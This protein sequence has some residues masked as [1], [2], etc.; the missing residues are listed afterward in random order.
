MSKF[1]FKIWR[2]KSTV[3]M[4]I[5]SQPEDTRN[6][7]ILFE[8]DGIKI[9]SYAYPELTPEMIYL[10][11]Y[12]HD[13]DN[14]V[15]RLSF[16]NIDKA[17]KYL[18]KASVALR[19]YAKSINI[20]DEEKAVDD[21]E[22]NLKYQFDLI[23]SVVV[24]TPIRIPKW[25][26]NKTSPIYSLKEFKI[27]R[28]STAAIYYD[29]LFLPGRSD[30]DLKKQATFCFN[31]VGDAKLWISHASMAIT[32]CNREY[33]HKAKPEERAVSIETTIAE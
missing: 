31:S 33:A 17:E 14:F 26:T 9:R 16:V 30:R 18:K 11:G 25:I 24:A 20:H 21:T 4:R 6:S 23:G 5:I 12:V 27:C 3:C 7:G 32:E 29:S 19:A 1:V 2:E 13:R 8:H 10:R 22:E 15:T 28:D